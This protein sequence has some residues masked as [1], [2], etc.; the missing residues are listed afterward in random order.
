M[1]PLGLGTD[2]YTWK[3]TSSPN[4]RYKPFVELGDD[5]R[6][7]SI[8]S[9]NERF[10]GNEP[11][12]INPFENPESR[13]RLAG[14]GFVELLIMWAQ[15][16]LL[17]GYSRRLQKTRNSVLRSP[18]YKPKATKVLEELTQHVSFGMDI[19][20]VA[21]ELAST[22]ERNYQFKLSVASFEPCNKE[23]YRNEDSLYDMLRQIT[24]ER[25]TWLRERDLSL[26]EHL[27]QYGSLVGSSSVNALTKVLIIL[28]VFLALMTFALIAPSLLSWLKSGVELI[29][30]LFGQLFF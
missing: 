25:A 11:Y 26:R 24:G 28:T 20:A 1:E 19:A 6:Y 3:S 30:P 14:Y 29:K 9:L 5:H 22:G 8:F 7:H 13:L 21:S 15:M 18:G 12:E 10:D 2:Y 16:H 4:I 23:L 17:D 27:S